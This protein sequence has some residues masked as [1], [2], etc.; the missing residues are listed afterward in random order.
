MTWYSSVKGDGSGV[1][2]LQERWLTAFS[3]KFIMVSCFENFLSAFFSR[4]SSFFHMV[5]SVMKY[6]RNLKEEYSES[7]LQARTRYLAQDMAASH[8]MHDASH[9][10]CLGYTCVV[11]LVLKMMASTTSSS[12]RASEKAEAMTMVS[13]IYRPLPYSFLTLRTQNY[14]FCLGKAVWS[15][16]L[17]PHLFLLSFITISAS[18][19]WAAVMSFTTA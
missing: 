19:Y 18:I 13:A 4:H 7:F 17:L 3:R 5:Q 10:T 1:L 9:T 11:K 12:S 8:F 6:A 14:L 16:P 15:A 2:H